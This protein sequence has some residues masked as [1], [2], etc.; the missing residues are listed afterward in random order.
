VVVHMHVRICACP[1]YMQE[2]NCD[3]NIGKR[4]NFGKEEYG[5]KS[6]IIDVEICGG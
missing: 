3:K 6:H 5:Y 2:I 1:T 4:H